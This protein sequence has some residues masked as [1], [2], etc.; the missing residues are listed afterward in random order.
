MK[1]LLKA[2]SKSVNTLPKFTISDDKPMLVELY[3]KKGG[4]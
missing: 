2:L 3:E 4:R 1:L